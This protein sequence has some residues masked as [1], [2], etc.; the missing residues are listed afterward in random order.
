[1]RP[2][3]AIKFTGISTDVAGTA[4]RS[5]LA[6]LALPEDGDTFTLGVL[7]YTFVDAITGDDEVLIGASIAAT[8]SNRRSTSPSKKHSREPLAV[9]SWN[10]TAKSG[11][12]TFAFP[13]A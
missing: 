3:E 6:F 9:S 2:T 11:R 1:M 7:T 10:G 12:S 8:I 5:H 4:A 13:R